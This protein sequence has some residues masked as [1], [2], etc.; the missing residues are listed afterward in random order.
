MLG[1][2][3]SMKKLIDKCDLYFE[4]HIISKELLLQNYADFLAGNFEKKHNVAISLHT[5]SICFDIITIV[6]TA[7]SNIVYN[8]DN[9]EDF[10]TSLNVGDMVLYKKT[11]CRFEGITTLSGE[12]IRRAVLYSETVT[13]G[14]VLE[15]REY[16]KEDWWNKI[17]P[18]N[19]KSTKFDARGIRTD[20]KKRNDFLSSVLEMETDE[21]PAYIEKSSVIVMNRERSERVIDNLEIVYDGKR[22]KITEIIPVSYCSEN[23]EYPYGGNPGKIEPAIKITN[24]I[25][26]A[27]SLVTGSWEGNKMWVHDVIGVSVIGFGAISRARTEVTEIMKR[28]KLKYVFVSY[29]IASE[30]GETLLD[31]VADASVFACTTEYLLNSSMPI[32]KQNPYTIELDKQVESVINHETKALPVKTFD[33]DWGSYRNVQIALARLRHSSARLAEDYVPLAH[34]MMN[35]MITSVFPLELMEDLVD[36]GILGVESPIQRIERLTEM[37]SQFIGED[38]DVAQTVLNFLEDGYLTLLTSSPKEKRLFALLE[39]NRGKRIALIVPKAYYANILY[40]QNILEY[41][42]DASHLS[43]ATANKFDYSQQY[44]IIIAIGAFWGKKFDPF[45]CRSASTIYVMVSAVE[46]NLFKYRRKLA[47]AVEYKFNV[48][49]KVP[50]DAIDIQEEIY[51]DGATEEEVAEVIGSTIDVAA[52][53]NQIFETRSLEMLNTG[54]GNHTGMSEISHIATCADGEK[55]FFT[56][57]YRAFVFDS[58]KEDVVEMSVDKLSPGDTVIFKSNGNETKDIVTTLLDKYLAEYNT[59]DIELQMA[60]LRSQLWKEVLREYRVRNNLSFKALAKRLEKCGSKKHEVTI[61]SW[62]ADDSYIVGPQDLETYIAIAEM[63][64]NQEMLADPKAFCDACDTIRRVRV[65]F[66]KLIAKTI[67]SKYSGRLTDDSDM[68]RVVSENIDDI[69]ILAQIE[70]ITPVM[71]KKAPINMINRP[72]SIN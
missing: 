42:D 31:E 57:K 72:I 6:F 20:N 19:G 66:L 7:I 25:S 68:A 60:Y 18:Y 11:R 24:N 8:Q 36:K 70:A 35:L 47:S 69:S 34:A 30:D 16:V 32:V 22:I 15:N 10:V 27:R 63:T 13:R 21:I 29:N 56:K 3:D 28:R 41:F 71:D 38:R 33:C 51:T 54:S 46:E 55:I 2:Y 44:D 43:I 9:A 5:G 49:A 58:A 67:I 65:G 14:L 1:V 48:Y 40:N 53:I 59:A 12:T 26:N 62:L 61:Q 52:Y 37:T 45:R 64:Q 4:G 39:E 50:M 23:E 17:S